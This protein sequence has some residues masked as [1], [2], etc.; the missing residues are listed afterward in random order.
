MN[1]ISVKPDLVAEDV[2]QALRLRI[3]VSY[4]DLRREVAVE[5][6]RLRDLRLLVGV[7]EPDFAV[8][9]DMINET[10]IKVVENVA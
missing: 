2:L 8:Y 3:V 4:R 6:R 5:V 10:I 1:R 7:E 9:R